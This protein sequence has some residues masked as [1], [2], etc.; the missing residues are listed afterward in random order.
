VSKPSDM[1]KNPV[2]QTCELLKS[3][4]NSSQFW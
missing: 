4:C 3:L 1:T 2:D